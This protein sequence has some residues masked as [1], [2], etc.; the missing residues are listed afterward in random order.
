MRLPGQLETIRLIPFQAKFQPSRTSSL[1]KNLLSANKKQIIKNPRL[2]EQLV[3]KLESRVKIENQPVNLT[4]D[5][6]QIVAD[7][8]KIKSKNKEEILELCDQHPR[9]LALVREA[10]PRMTGKNLHCKIDFNKFG[11]S[12]MDRLLEK[13][14]YQRTIQYTVQQNAWMEKEAM[15]EWV[16]GIWKPF[17]DEKNE[18][19]C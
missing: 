4:F 18:C 13:F 11:Y 9:L 14:G 16:T 3:K 8:V 17:T 19:V 5:M 10:N 12:K 1:K 7:L 15:L 2:R 6:L